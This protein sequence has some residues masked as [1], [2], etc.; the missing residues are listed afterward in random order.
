MKGKESNSPRVM[1]LLVVSFVEV[2]NLF[3][4]RHG[5]SC[6]TI[7]VMWGNSFFGNMHSFCNLRGLFSLFLLLFNSGFFGP[8]DKGVLVSFKNLAGAEDLKQEGLL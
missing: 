2:V 6:L 7:N 1:L 8:S 4:C 5:P 3:R